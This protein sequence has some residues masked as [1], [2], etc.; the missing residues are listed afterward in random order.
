M[1][2]LPRPRRAYWGDIRFFIGIALVILSI[3]GVW[4]IVS[5]SRHTTPVLQANRTIVQGDALVSAD[6]QVVDVGLGTATEG[7]LGPQQL[8][9]GMV[10]TRTLTK[11]EL[12][13]ATATTEAENSRSTTIVVES[14]TGIPEGVTAGTVVEL[15]HSPLQPDGETFDAPRILVA[16]VVVVSVLEPEGMLASSRTA[17]EVVVDR[18]DVAEVLAAMNGGSVLSLVPLGAE[19]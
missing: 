5:S 13:P 4:L 6:F 15:W 17:V 19:S 18:A 14:G 8:R 10:A 12:V 9:P 16:D 3:L 2:T 7:Y 11:G 1:T